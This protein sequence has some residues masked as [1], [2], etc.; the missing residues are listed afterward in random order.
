LA[1]AHDAVTRFPTG[2]TSDTTTGDRTFT[3]T[4][5]GTPKGVVVIVCGTGNASLVTGVLY[6]NIAMTLIQT[7]DDTTEAGRVQIYTLTETVV[8]TGAQTV[9]LVGCIAAAKYATCCT[10]TT[11]TTGSKVNASNAVNTT[12]STTPLVNVTTTAATCGYSGFHHGLAAPTTA[13]TGNT[14]L[15]SMDYGALSSQTHRRTANA[16]ASGTIAHQTAVIASDDWCGAAVNLE[17]YTIPPTIL[18]AEVNMA[19]ER[20]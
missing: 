9:T 16:E 8:P 2:T 17:E 12:V 11:A 13:G 1:I 19:R 3:H 10:V 15:F 4:P 6:G 20:T 7:A 14:L 18:I 5:T